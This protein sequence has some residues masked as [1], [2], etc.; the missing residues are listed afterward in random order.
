MPLTPRQIADWCHPRSNPDRWFDHSVSQ[1]TAGHDGDST[2][3]AP[4]RL[5]GI[6][7]H[8]D[9]ESYLSAGLMA[10][11]TAAGGAV[12]VLTITNGEAGFPEDDH[13]PAAVRAEQRQCEMRSAMQVVGVDDVRFLDVPDGRVE[14]ASQDALVDRIAEVIRDV[15]PDVIVTFGPDG[16]TGHSDHIANCHL[17]TRAWMEV[18][19]GSLWYAA[20]TQ[21][22]LDEWR[23][24][25]DRFGVWMTGEPTGVRANDIEM[26]VDLG[27]TEVLTKRAVLAEHRSQTEALSAAFGESEYRRW[28]REEAFRRPTEAE[29]SRYTPLAGPALVGAH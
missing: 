1:S 28:I 24:L 23:E 10:R 7:A 5:L 29:L 8:P 9:D 4:P 3:A 26:I 16:I 11:T 20:K 25:H 6:W 15:H 14:D 13:R 27:S 21:D 18:R 22:W 2:P 17:A 19:V 12:T